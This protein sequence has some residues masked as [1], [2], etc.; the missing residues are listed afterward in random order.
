MTQRQDAPVRFC[1]REITYNSNM[2]TPPAL[3]VPPLNKRTRIPMR[4]IRAI[5]QHIVEE[6]EPEQIILFGSHAYGKPN[7]WSDNSCCSTDP[8]TALAI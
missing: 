8:P 1:C 4:A 2:A 5:V 3:Q 7:A 6:F